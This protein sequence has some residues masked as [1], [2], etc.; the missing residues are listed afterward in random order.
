MENSMRLISRKNYITTIAAVTALLFSGAAMAQDHTS[1]SFDDLD[2][3]VG[4]PGISFA[5]LWGDWTKEEYGMIVKIK[6]GHAA[7]RHSHTFDYHGVSIQGNWV[8][9]YDKSDDRTLVPGG[10]AFQSGKED[11]DDRCEGTQDCLILIH[12]HGPRDFIVSDK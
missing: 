3:V 8:H 10:Y 4:G 6:A 12:Q 1:R 5:Q 2:W 9:T 7:P 11:H